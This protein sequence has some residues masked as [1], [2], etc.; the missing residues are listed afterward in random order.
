MTG[1]FLY[2]CA[3]CKANRRSSVIGAS[4]NETMPKGN[5][6]DLA[7]LRR[8]M[9]HFREEIVKVQVFNKDVESS[10]TNLHDSMTAVEK[11]IL[12][13]ESK[14]K[15]LDEV[16]EENTRLRNQ[17]GSI[18]KRLV[19]LE[20]QRKHPISKKHPATKPNKKEAVFK[21]T[22]S[23]IPQVDGEDLD[24]IASSIVNALDASITE[25][26]VKCER[27][28][29]KEPSNSVL[30]L[31]MKDDVSLNF[32]VKRAR[33]MKPTGALIGG[34]AA[35]RIFVNEKLPTALYQLLREA[36][37]LR[38]HGYK[39]VWSQYGKVLARKA[40]GERASIIRNKSDLQ[41]LMGNAN[42]E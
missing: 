10:L 3:K 31:T 8:E 9:S 16:L 12:S 33:A 18:E 17:I 20:S 27:L 4:L 35:T 24:T 34:D 30:V 25:S 22:V 32:L 38:S 28:S 36:R 13:F 6:D 15:L 14:F 5:S 21:A 29:A 11:C 19:V 42:Q 39:F 26:I 37:E 23:G 2:N 7:N 40:E 1:D 41:I